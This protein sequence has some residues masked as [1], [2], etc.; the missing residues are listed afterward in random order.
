LLTEMHETC[1][2]RNG[3]LSM[4][5]Q[6]DMLMGEYESI[7]RNELITSVYQ[8]IVSLNSGEAF[9]YEA[10]TRG[11]EG[12]HFHSPLRLFEYAEK[13]G[14]LYELDYLT[15]H[16]AIQG[17]SDLNERQKLFI[18]IPSHIMSDPRFTPGQTLKKLQMH[19]LH[20]NNIVFEITERSSIEDFSAAKAV[21]NHYRNQG[22]QIAIDDAGAGYSSLQAI[23]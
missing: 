13:H 5:Q 3:G 19:G 10:L 1:R 6:K 16:R 22:Y 2:E 18:N 14:S 23:A 7:L 11:P 20:P 9:G 17:G 8:P 12:S 15:R 4:G 21:L